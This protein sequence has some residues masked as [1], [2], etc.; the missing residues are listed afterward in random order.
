MIL[1]TEIVAFFLYRAD[2]EPVDQKKLLEDS[3]KPKCVRPLL[4]YQVVSKYAVIRCFSNL[5][6]PQTY[7]S[8]PCYHAFLF[9]FFPLPL[10][11]F[12]FLC[13]NICQSKLN[14][15][16]VMFSRTWFQKDQDYWQLV[17]MGIKNQNVQ[18]ELLLFP[19]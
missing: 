5:Y 1:S 15:L 14:M 11:S 9:M 12:V 13:V 18:F 4:E 17:L 6:L 2:E 16:G 10:C 7:N 8:F 3:C 19:S